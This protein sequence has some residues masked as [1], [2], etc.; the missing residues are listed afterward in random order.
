MARTLPTVAPYETGKRPAVDTKNNNDAATTKVDA[1]LA[2]NDEATEKFFESMASY[3]E[4]KLKVS[5]ISMLAR[6]MLRTTR[7][8]VVAL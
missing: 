1:L 4:E 6:I 7:T 3:F 2:T 8:I 5:R